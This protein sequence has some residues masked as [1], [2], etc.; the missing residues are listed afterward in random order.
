MDRYRVMQ[1]GRAC[2]YVEKFGPNIWGLFPKWRAVGDFGPG[3]FAVPMTHYFPTKEDA[4]R[5]MAELIEFANGTK[6]VAA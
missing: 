5:Y 4:Q 6:M 1:A 3:P 2:F